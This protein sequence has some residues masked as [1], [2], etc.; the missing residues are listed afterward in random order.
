[1]LRSKEVLRSILGIVTS[2]KIDKA[3]SDSEKLRKGDIICVTF[4][5]KKKPVAHL[6]R[7]QSRDRNAATL[8]YNVTWLNA[9]GSMAEVG[10]FDPA[11]DFNWLP[12]SKAGQKRPREQDDDDEDG[13]S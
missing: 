5:E 4:I 7:I 1:M 2:Y 6:A 8:R 13:D 9:D 12:I 3:V 10:T 11:M